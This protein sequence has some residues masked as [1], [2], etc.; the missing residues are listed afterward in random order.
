LTNKIRDKINTY[1]S[2]WKSFQSNVDER[3]KVLENFAIFCKNYSD[4]NEGKVCF[5][6]NVNQNRKINSNY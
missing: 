1:T 4:L 6:L 5:E 3:L 2:G